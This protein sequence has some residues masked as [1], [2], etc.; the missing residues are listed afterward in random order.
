MTAQKLSYSCIG[1]VSRCV[2]ALVTNQFL[3]KVFLLN[4]AKEVLNNFLTIYFQ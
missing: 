4:L 2:Y 1:E 3:V